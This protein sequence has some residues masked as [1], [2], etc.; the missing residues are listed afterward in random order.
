MALLVISG[1]ALGMAVLVVRFGVRYL[2]AR[3][4]RRCRQ[5]A[6][7][8]RLSALVG[9]TEALHELVAEAS[10]QQLC[11]LW[12]RSGREITTVRLASSLSWYADLRRDILDE[13]SARNPEAIEHWLAERPEAD[14]R[15]YLRPRS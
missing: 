5:R 12:E 4:R 6:Y 13:L 3:R 10:D 9:V 1:V 11:E 14:P 8:G 15:T 2:E 7:E